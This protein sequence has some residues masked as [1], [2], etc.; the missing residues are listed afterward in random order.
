MSSDDVRQNA[1][2]RYKFLESPEDP[3][4]NALVSLCAEHFS[5]PVAAV[6]FVETRSLWLKARFGLEIKESNRQG[7]FCDEVLKLNTPLVIEDATRDTRF[8]GSPLVDGP[9]GFRFY[10]GIPLRTPENV[11]LGTLFLLDRTPRQFTE[12]MIEQ[13]T[14]FSKQ[15]I[16]EVLII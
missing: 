16:R 15:V 5:V 7:S 12:K 3:E 14:T 1:L 13:L 11:T 10:A 6:C 9:E 4:L 8:S 2:D